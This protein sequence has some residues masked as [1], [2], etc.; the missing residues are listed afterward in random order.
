MI[1][2]N[3]N[4]SD[5]YIN[6]IDED[7]DLVIRIGALDDSNLITKKLMPMPSLLCASE[8]YLKIMAYLK[9]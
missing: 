4:L 5:S 9:Q 3:I 2:Q 8:Q 1:I 6:I 7:F